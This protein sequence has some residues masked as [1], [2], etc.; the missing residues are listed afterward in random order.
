MWTINKSIYDEFGKKGLDE[1]AMNMGLLANLCREKNIVLTI[2]IYPWPDQIIYHDLDSIQYKFWSNWAKK[3][4]VKI[5]NYFPYFI[6]S[7]HNTV[8]IRGIMDT[9]FI[10]GD[11]HW[12]SEGHRKV[13]NIFLQNFKAS[14]N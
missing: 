9:Y 6:S 11:A 8:D 7:N 4:D 13:A 10:P 12:N 2:A 5:I 14:I 1:S 3:N